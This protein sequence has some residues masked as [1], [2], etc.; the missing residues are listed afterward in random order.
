MLAPGKAVVR[1]D[2]VPHPK[3]ALA[4]KVHVDELLYGGAGGGGKSRWARAEAVLLCLRVPGVRVVIFRRTFKD[5]QRS[6]VMELR[7]EIPRQLA[8]YNKTDHEFKFANGSILELGHLQRETDLDK[9][10]GAEYQLVVFEEATHFTLDQ[11]LYLKSRL[12]TAGDL[13]DRLQA[14]GLR[15]RMI[16]TAN[17]G[18]VGHN[19]VKARF[20]DPVASGT[21]FRTRPSAEEPN[22]GTRCYIPA[23]ATDNP[24]LNPEYHDLLNAL[25]ENRR[26]AMRDGDWNILDGVRFAGWREGAHVIDPGELPIPMLTGQKV[27]CV[28]YGFSAPFAAVWLCKLHDDLVV[29]YREV[30][31]TELTAVQQAELIRDLSAEEEAETGDKIPI[32]MDPAMW[33]RQDASAH[34]T[35]DPNAPPV[36]SPAHD[37][38]RVLNRT[39]HKGVNART[40]GWNLLDEKLRIRPEDGLP[41]FLV[42]SSCRDLIRTLPSLPRDRRNPED[43]DTTTEDHLADALRYGLMYL[44]GKRVGVKSPAGAPA[45]AANAPLTAGIYGRKF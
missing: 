4:H 8:T 36:G 24:S 21:V 11:Y 7:K 18:G 25:P 29:A 38:Q 22:P 31:G 34:K 5:L 2:Y 26:K 39:P 14:I 41:R 28:D 20:V 9:Y 13:R 35:L 15:P 12:R 17:P 10:Q 42:Y 6:V 30:Y 43:V 19:W 33:R 37:Y 27:I 23:R 40:H 45:A 3:Q 16:A 1:Y 32:V 44:S